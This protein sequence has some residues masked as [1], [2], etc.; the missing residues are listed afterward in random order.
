MPAQALA[1]AATLLSFAP[2]GNRI[3]LVFDRGSAEITW[4]SANT[5][6]FRRALDGALAGALPEAPRQATSVDIED[7]PAALR[8]R[9]KL[10][11]VS[12]SDFT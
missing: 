11:G 5:F 1:V 8:F 4:F 2:H 10:L 3:E 9:S 6:R 7:T 12:R